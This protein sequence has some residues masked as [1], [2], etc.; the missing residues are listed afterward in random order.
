M[1]SFIKNLVTND[2]DLAEALPLLRGEIVRKAPLAKKTWLG[3]GGPADFLYTPADEDD[4]RY[5]LT[6]RPNLPLTVLGGGSNLLVRDGGVP[7]IVLQL[8]APFDKIE[9]EGDFI[10]CGTAVKNTALAQTALQ[11][12]LS[13]FEFLCGI[14]GTVGGAL[15]M[16]A[17]A[18]G[19]C[20]RDVVRE[21]TVYDTNGRKSTATQ[22]ELFFDYRQSAMPENWIFIKALMKGTHAPE[23]DIIAKMNEYK[24]LREQNQPMGV[25]TAGSM[26]KNPVG[27]KAWELIDKA[28]CRGMK[29]GDAQVSE[30]HCNFF[31]NTGNATANDLETL[32]LDVQKRVFDKFEIELE[33]EVRRVGVKTKRF[34][35][36]GGK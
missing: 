35:S 26:F 3:V 19:R 36:F 34:S 29:R 10:K 18:H 13:G 24:A 15:R 33:W 21:I 11:A 9:I 14:P 32:A 5:F 22:S 8:G 16:N 1:L 20:M 7:G 2:F 4:L 27:L 12:G 25:K 30:K 23:E 28:G 6:A 17:G 31:I